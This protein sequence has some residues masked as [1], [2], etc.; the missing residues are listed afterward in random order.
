LEFAGKLSVGTSVETSVNW[1]FK[2]ELQVEFSV[3][4][5]PCSFQLKLRSELHGGI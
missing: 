2:L 3:G 4:S 1:N 5:F